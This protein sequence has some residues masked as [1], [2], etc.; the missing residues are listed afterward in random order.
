M[1]V[2]FDLLA[3]PSELPW[4]LTIHY[5]TP[6]PSSTAT[7]SS[8]SSEPSSAAAGWENGLPS[9]ALFYHSLK[10][11]A[12]ICRGPD[13]AASVMKMTGTAQDALWAALERADQD[14]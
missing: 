8:S 13:G 11:A 10:E 14:R 3:S 12:F 5:T 1:G 7:T 9:Q 2:L 4:D 6:H